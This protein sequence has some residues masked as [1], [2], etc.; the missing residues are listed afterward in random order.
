ME[1]KTTLNKLLAV[2]N[3]GIDEAK[4]E[5]AR[6]SEKFAE[7][8][9]YAFEWATGSVEAA[10]KLRAWSRVREALT[11]ADT[12]ATPETIQLY[13]TEEVLRGARSPKRSTS[14]MSNL[15]DE[16]TLAAQAELLDQMR[17]RVFA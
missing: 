3:R 6:F 7:D 14:P 10:A 1:P 11:T 17:W 4:A 8:P 13:L 15:V 9:A 12:T 5:L 16:S 2:L